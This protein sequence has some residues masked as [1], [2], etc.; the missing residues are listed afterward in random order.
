MKKETIESFEFINMRVSGMRFTNE[1]EVLMKD[2]TV[3]VVLYNIRYRDQKDER[4]VELK[5][6]CDKEKMLKLLND[7]ELLSWDGFVGNHPKGVHDGIMFNMNGLINDKKISASGSEN[8][9]KHYR[10]FTDGLMN[11]L[12][13]AE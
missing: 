12:K 8:F 6:T 9:P 10:E 11:I 1:Y 7:C 13:E 3:E 2:D 5:N 4:I